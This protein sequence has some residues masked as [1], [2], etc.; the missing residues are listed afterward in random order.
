MIRAALLA[1]VIG[2]ASP[3]FAAA[4]VFLASTP[5]SELSVGPLFVNAT[6]TPSLGSV[7]VTVSW[8]LSMPPPKQLADVAQ[9]LYLLWPAEMAAGTAPGRAEPELIRHVADRGFD[10]LGDGRLAMRRRDRRQRSARLRS[11][12]NA[13]LSGQGEHREP[14]SVEARSYAA[15]LSADPHPGGRWSCGVRRRAGGVTPPRT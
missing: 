11:Y 12:S 7:T 6:V 13:A 4:Q 10:V 5:H 9:D 3:A 15:T 1:G 2:L 14:W 8:S